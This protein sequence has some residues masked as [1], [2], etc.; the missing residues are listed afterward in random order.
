MALL[1]LI[2]NGLNVEFR[3]EFQ[4]FPKNSG[5]LHNF[6]DVKSEQNKNSRLSSC[7]LLANT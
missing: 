6:E 1:I 7:L 3:N 5:K 4:N 2:L